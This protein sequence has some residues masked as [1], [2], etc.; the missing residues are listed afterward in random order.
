VKDEATRR[1]LR[2]VNAERSVSAELAS[3][4]WKMIF[5]A[6]SAARAR[7]SSN[8]R[9]TRGARRL[10]RKLRIEAGEY[11][12]NCLRG[13][14]ERDVVHPPRPTHKASLDA[15]CEALGFEVKYRTQIVDGWLP[16]PWGSTIYIRDDVVGARSRFTLAHELAHVWMAR[17]THLLSGL[18]L[19]ELC[20]QDEE[21]VCDAA[22]AALLLP[23]DTVKRVV[24]KEPH[25]RPLMHLAAAM[26]VSLPTAVN[27]VSDLG[28]WHCLLI[29]WERIERGWI[30]RHTSG[31]RANGGVFRA[32]P[33]CFDDVAWFEWTT[34]SFYDANGVRLQGVGQRGRKLGNR[35]TTFIVSLK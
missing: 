19:D 15:I 26:E 31:S 20:W 24:G 28:H 13:T 10:P 18:G 6:A 14:L 32:A 3:A 27:R 29:E 9:Q 11:I 1:E 33:G 25:L 2:S 34:F 22:A 21:K 16:D 17:E 23:A 8:S 12:A 4:G 5:E 7:S 30:A 35:C